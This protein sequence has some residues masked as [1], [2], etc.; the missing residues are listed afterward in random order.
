MNFRCAVETDIPQLTAMRLAYLSEDYHGLSQEQTGSIKLQLKDYFHKHLSNDLFVY[1]C[2]DDAHIVSTVFMVVIEK[3][4]NPSF[5]T[6]KTGMILNVY[7]IPNCRKQGIAG[8]LIKMAV[9]DAKQRKLSFLELKATADGLSLY[10]E[11]GFVPE[12]SQYT[13]MKYQLRA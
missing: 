1:V 8:A 2:E 10:T 5:L 12:T 3:P 7:T 6:G 11:L 9:E 4:A 13:S